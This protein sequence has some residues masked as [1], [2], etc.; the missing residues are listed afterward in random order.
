MSILNDNILQEL[1]KINKRLDTIEDR[2][3]KIEEKCDK[4]ISHIFFIENTYDRI[5]KPFNFIIDK[6]NNNYLLT[7]Y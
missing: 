6:I 4:M 2:L 5:K 1:H 3:V 7:D